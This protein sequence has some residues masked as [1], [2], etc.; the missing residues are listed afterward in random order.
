MTR[1]SRPAA[2]LIL[3]L[4]TGSGTAE[5]P[6]GDL[7]A[8]AGHDYR[9]VETEHFRLACPKDFRSE[10]WLADRMEA[11]F[12]AVLAF[13]RGLD[14]PAD[15]GP[16]RLEVVLF[17]G[18]AELRACAG[19]LGYDAGDAMGFYHAA[20]RRTYLFDPASDPRCRSLEAELEALRRQIDSEPDPARRRDLQ[21]RYNT[22]STMLRYWQKQT[23]RMV[24]Q[25]ELAH[26]VLAALGLHRREAGSNPL[27]LVEGLACLFE[28]PIGAR[29][30]PAGVNEFRLA[31]LRTALGVAADAA[32]IPPEAVHE[33][34]RRGALVPL[35]D[36][37]SL[38]QDA[39]PAGHSPS[40]LYAQCWGFVQFLVERYPRHLAAY[41]RSVAASGEPAPDTFKAAFGRTPEAMEAEWAQWL[42]TL[43]RPRVGGRLF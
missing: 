13:C 21:R 10:K 19:R 40:A 4:A 1:L 37:V 24:I 30:A 14:L 36:L 42:A 41:I 11:T 35:S 8:L 9:I 23:A 5:D 31:D 17:A 3:A 39:P 29:G 27:W 26:Q 15:P 25:H 43:R 20:T 6:P 28:S 32:S 34:L 18:P 2:A 16:Q 38:R 33:A 22:A 12:R 7:L